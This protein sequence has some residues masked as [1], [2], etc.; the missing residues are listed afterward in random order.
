MA[1][2]DGYGQMRDGSP[3]A[4]DNTNG[5]YD[6]PEP[7]PQPRHKPPRLRERNVSHDV[8]YCPQGYWA[9]KE[10]ALIRIRA[11]SDNHLHN[12]MKLLERKARTRAMIEIMAI[13]RYIESAPEHA[14]DAAD[15]AAVELMKLRDDP[16]TDLA[17]LAQLVWP[18]YRELKLEQVRRRELD[19][20]K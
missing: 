18:K 1:Y 4:Y 13:G 11:M 3:P 8:Q 7:W 6:D 20:T 19:T 12:S 10:G 16:N 15:E 17:E 9:T 5:Q 14:A 2:I